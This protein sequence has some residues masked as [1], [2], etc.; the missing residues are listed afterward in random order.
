LSLAE[1][2]KP[3]ADGETT[4]VVSAGHMSE[5]APPKVQRPPPEL[6]QHTDE[7]LA[8]LGYSASDISRLRDNGVV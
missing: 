7:I 2:P 5:P 3:G 8:E 4:R 6:G 1:I